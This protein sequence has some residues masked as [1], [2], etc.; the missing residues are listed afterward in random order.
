MLVALAV[1][2]GLTAGAAAQCSQPHGGGTATSLALRLPMDRVAAGSPVLVDVTVSNTSDQDVSIWGEAPDSF[3]S[4]NVRDFEGRLPVE[5]KSG[6]YRQPRE[7]QELDTGDVQ[8]TYLR[9]SG[10]ACF[11]LKKATS[12]TNR[13]DAS[14]PYDLSEPGTYTIVLG[15]RDPVSGEEVKSNSVTVTVF[16]APP[17]REA[18]PEASPAPAARFSVTIDRAFCQSHSSAWV[19]VITK[20]TSNRRLII[21]REEHEDDVSFLGQVFRLDTRDKAGGAPRETQLA[22]TTAN[23]ADTAP[24]PSFMRSARAAGL[25]VSLGPGEDWWD[26]I[27][28]NDLYDLHK[29]GTYTLQVR[30]WDDETKTWVKSN[31][32]T[33]TVT[34]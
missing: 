12:F 9:S 4:V 31:T 14:K 11:T 13:V 32:I 18:Q 22:R 20:N 1:A 6:F 15:H 16:P 24:D 23:A 34:P 19:H 3:Y 10:G 29:P 33:L 2:F 17:V 30:R 27:K 7:V 8:T 25:L 5:T 26:T 28:V 21:R